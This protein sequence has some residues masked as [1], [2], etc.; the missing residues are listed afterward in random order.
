MSRET[1][2]TYTGRQP[3]NLDAW[4]IGEACSAASKASAG[5]PIDRGLVL[6]REL[7]AKGFAILPLDAT[8]NGY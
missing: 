8:R 5:D 2:Y 1:A 4:R 6:L 7:E 3:G